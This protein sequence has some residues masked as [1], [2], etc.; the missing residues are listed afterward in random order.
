MVKQLLQK[1]QGDTLDEF[2]QS[3]KKVKLPMFNGD[4]PASWI[5]RVEVYFRVQ[6]T[7]EELK[8]SLAQLCMDGPTRVEAHV[9]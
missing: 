8:V 6:G 1:L 9:G 5:A 3:V 4:D 7:R 2:R